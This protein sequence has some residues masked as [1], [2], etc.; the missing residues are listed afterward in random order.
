MPKNPFK[1][2]SLNKNV[3]NNIAQIEIQRN[4]TSLIVKF[5]IPVK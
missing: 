5:S 3:M 2:N 1:T 4:E